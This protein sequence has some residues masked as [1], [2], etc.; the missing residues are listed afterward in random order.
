MVTSKYIIAFFFIL[1]CFLSAPVYAGGV[2]PDK[3]NGAGHEPAMHSS[4][5]GNFA[6]GERRVSEPD[7]AEGRFLVAARRLDRYLKS[8]LF[9]LLITPGTELQGLS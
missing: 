9:C 4:V 6:P 1:F 5:P 3:G 2:S 7:P 8:L